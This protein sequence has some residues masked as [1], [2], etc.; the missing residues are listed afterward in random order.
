MPQTYARTETTTTETGWNRIGNPDNP[1][2]LS[3]D[4]K[5]TIKFEMP[6]SAVPQTITGLRVKSRLHKADPLMT[7]I[8]AFGS[9]DDFITAINGS[10]SLVTRVS[11]KDH[12]DNDFPS[13]T[14]IGLG[15]DRVLIIEMNFAAYQALTFEIHCLT[16]ITSYLT[17]ITS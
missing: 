6:A 3:T 4:T 16:G 14:I 2:E 11:I 15:S 8:T 5:V 10:L 9:T 1:Y 17:V 13:D 7:H 12:A